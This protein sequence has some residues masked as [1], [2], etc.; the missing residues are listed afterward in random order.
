MYPTAPTGRRCPIAFA[1]PSVAA[2]LLGLML[3]VELLASLMAEHGPVE[4]A[5]VAF[6]VVSA[7]AVLFAAAAGAAVLAIEEVLELCPPLLAW[8]AWAQA[9]YSARLQQY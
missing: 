2:L 9:R 4:L 3:P 8:L 1:I 6:Y 5:T 7:L